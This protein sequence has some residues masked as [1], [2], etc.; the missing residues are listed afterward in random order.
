[1]RTYLYNKEKLKKKKKALHFNKLLD[2]K[3]LN[4]IYSSVLTNQ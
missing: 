4:F 1:M 2:L 3:I